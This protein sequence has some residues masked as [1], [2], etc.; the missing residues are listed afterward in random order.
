V[1]QPEP[2]NA[3][4][5]GG[6]LHGETH[7]LAHRLKY[8]EVP[9]PGE[10]FFARLWIERPDCADAFLYEVTGADDAETLV[11]SSLEDGPVESA[12]LEGA[13]AQAIAETFGAGPDGSPPAG[14][15]RGPAA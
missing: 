8:V 5:V 15:D 11:Y 6:P 10:S 3:R 4:F 13:V 9:G 1:I 12:D 14:S 2:I 7:V